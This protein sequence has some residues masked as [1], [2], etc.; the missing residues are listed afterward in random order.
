VRRI[1]DVPGYCKS[2]VQACTQHFTK[3]FK[4]I[5]TECQK[6]VK[7]CKDAFKRGYSSWSLPIGGKRAVANSSAECATMFHQQCRKFFREQISYSLHVMKTKKVFATAKTKK[8]CKG[9]KFS[10]DCKS[11]LQKLST[12]LLTHEQGHFD[13]A[14]VM[15][16][17]TKAA[18]KAKAATLVAEETRCGKTPAKKAAFAAFGKLNA[19]AALQEIYD[20]GN[21]GKNKADEDY[22]NDTD[23]GLKDKEQAV[24]EKR[25]ADGLKAY[26]VPKT[27]KP[28]GKQTTP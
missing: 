18:L 1:R 11:F 10:D 7:E 22:D 15:A 21:D 5:E 20:D 23:H 16:D 14:K 12:K 2:Q 4:D 26:P 8:D 27:H 9:K 25:I 19:G 17:K 28:Q 24:W 13:L 3:A 6:N